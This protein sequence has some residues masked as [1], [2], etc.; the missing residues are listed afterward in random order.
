MKRSSEQIFTSEKYLV[1][2]SDDAV[3]ACLMV[4]CCTNSCIQKLFSVDKVRQ[5]RALFHGQTEL[6]KS[7][8]L[9]SQLT[10]SYSLEKN[11]FKFQAFGSSIC[12]Q[13]FISIYGI[14]NGKFYSIFSKFKSGTTEIQHGNS[15]FQHSSKKQDIVRTWLK[16]FKENFADTSPVDPEIAYLPMMVHHVDLYEEFIKAQIFNGLEQFEFPSIMTFLLVW[17][18]EFKCLR[19][20]R[21][22]RLGRCSFC[23]QVNL[24]ITNAPNQIERH[25]LQLIKQHHLSDIFKWRGCYDKRKLLAKT[26]PL[27]FTSW[28]CDYIDPIK[29]PH[30]TIF[31]SA[32]LTKKRIK[33]EICGFLD[34]T[35]TGNEATIFVHTEHF[36]HSADLLI[37]IFFTK[38]KMSIAEGKVSRNLF[39]QAD[40]CAKET[41]NQL[42]FTFLAFLVQIGLFDSIELSSLPPGHTHSDV[43]SEIFAVLKS[44]LKVCSIEDITQFINEFLPKLNQRRK[45]KIKAVLVSKIYKWEEFFQGSYRKMSHHQDKHQF[46][47]CIPSNENE[48]HFFYRNTGPWQ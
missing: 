15:F 4:K 40:N 32:W 6:E 36:S 12:R 33:L 2:T 26:S 7:N 38:L 45:K 37:S 48:V 29:I 41:H 34:H 19:C 25:E 9:L 8:W 11:T 21:M 28:A 5:C 22:I 18:R 46:R 31:P 10:Q 42:F 35:C 27:L 47:W 13:C 24:K 23:T 44:M 17:R 20:S 16:E 30:P 3:C 39:L 14:S 43:D 1:A